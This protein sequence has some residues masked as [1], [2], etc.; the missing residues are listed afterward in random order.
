VSPGLPSGDS[1]YKTIIDDIKVKYSKGGCLAWHN[2][3]DGTLR[4]EVWEDDGDLILNCREDTA[5]Y[6][7]S[8]CDVYIYAP[9]ASINSITLKGRPETHLYVCGEIGYVRNF[10]L[11]YGHVGDTLSYGP[12][13]G[14]GSAALDPPRKILIKAGWS[15]APVLGVG[16]PGL[17]SNP[18][19]AEDEAGNIELKPKPFEVLLDEDDE[20]TGERAISEASAAEAKEA[21]TFEQ[22][23]IKV[24]YSEPG[25]NADYDPVYGLLTIQIT[26]SD[27]D[28]LV[29]CGYIDAPA[30]SINTINLKGRPETQL[31]VCG[32]VYYVKNFK[33]K[34]GCVGDTGYFGPDYGLGCSSS[35]PPNKILIKWGWTTAPVLGVSY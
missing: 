4:I 11:K 35:E 24:I 25:C 1:S 2:A 23:D 15:T 7:G 5:S 13:I 18:A 6:W 30:A 19:E 33:L 22:G 34:Y 26:E 27:G 21:Y 29:K 3:L 14:L 17:L 28:L 8:R 20:D 16:Y 32:Q 31:Y 12:D 10:K 9:D